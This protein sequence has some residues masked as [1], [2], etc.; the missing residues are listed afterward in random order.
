MADAPEDVLGEPGPRL[1]I[2]AAVSRGAVCHAAS[3]DRIVRTGM[4]FSSLIVAPRP[5]RHEAR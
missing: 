2:F 1:G 5:V 4:H 3:C